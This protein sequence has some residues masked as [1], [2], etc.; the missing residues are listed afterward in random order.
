MAS[1]LILINSPNVAVANE[2]DGIEMGV[3]TDGRTYLTGRSLARL[4]GV[5][6]STIVAQAKRWADGERVG[7]LAQ[8][9]VKRGVSQESLY[10]EVTTEGGARVT[11]YTDDVCMVF[12]EYYA[13][14]SIPV[15]PV[16]QTNYRLLALAGM[17]VFV[18]QALG[19]DPVRPLSDAW[20]HFHDRLTLHAVPSGYFSVFR[21]GA[22]FVLASIRAGLPNDHET[23]PDISVGKI[24]SA[25]WTD[26]NLAARF[27]ERIKHDHNYPDDYPQAKSNPQEIWVYP[28]DAIG[29]FR[30]WLDAT[31]LPTKYPAYLSGKVKKG[32][33]AASTVELLLA[34]VAPLALPEAESA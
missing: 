27:G 11:A 33:L 4:C 7:K 21:E 32:I 22:D 25:F 24:W 6:S 15:S 10:V 5:A 26:K 14:D 13:F 17:R 18:Y 1:E 28:V 3:L 16:G 31:Y 20:R 34:E 9:F 30:R 8:L 2:I 29:E 19:Y 23:I 12:L